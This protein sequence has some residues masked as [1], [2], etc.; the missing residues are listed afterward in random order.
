MHSE[1]KWMTTLGLTDLTDCLVPSVFLANWLVCIKTLVGTTSLQGPVL[2]NTKSFP[3][4][5]YMKAI[6]CDHL[7]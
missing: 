7:S 6:A 3:V 2:Q 5:H 4:K 1:Y